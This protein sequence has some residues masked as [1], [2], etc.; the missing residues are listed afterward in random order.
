VEDEKTDGYIGDPVK[1]LEYFEALLK[2][3][4]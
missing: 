4:H 1:Y 3:V 2:V